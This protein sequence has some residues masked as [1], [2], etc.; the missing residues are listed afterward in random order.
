MVDKVAVC[1]SLESFSVFN[2]SFKRGESIRFT[3]HN[4]AVSTVE[5]NG[6]G[7]KVRTINANGAQTE[8]LYDGHGI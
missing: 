6:L 8:Y 4:G 3:D 2:E 1:L 5:T 7:Q